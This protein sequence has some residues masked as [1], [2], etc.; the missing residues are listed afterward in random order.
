MPYFSRDDIAQ[1]ATPPGPAP[2]GAIRLSG[3][4]AFAILGRVVDEKPP[5]GMPGR[6]V[7]PARL[8]LR[9]AT[10][11]RPSGAREEFRCPVRVFLMPA[12]ASYTRED[13]VELH[14]SGAP[15]LLKAALSSLIAA[16]A[17]AAEPGEFTFRAFR[18]GRLGLA[19]AEAVEAVVRAGGDAERRRALAR[20]GDAGTARMLVWRDRVMDAAARLEA[21][22]DFSEEELEGDAA[23]GLVDLAAELEREGVGLAESDRGTADD[24]PH[25][26]LVGLTNA[27]KSS[28]LNALLGKDAV[29]ASPEASTTRDSLRHPVNWYGAA[30]ILSDNPGHDPGSPAAE[31]A[32]RRLGGE[33]LACWVVDGSC[34][35]DDLIRDFAGRLSGRVVVA[36]NKTD[37]PSAVAVDVWRGVAARTGVQPVAVTTVSAA[38]GYGIDGLRHILADLVRDLPSSSLW[39]R[40]ETFELTAALGHCRAAADELSGPGRLEL[41]SEELRQAALAFSRAMGEGYAEEAL[42]RIFSSFC[43]GK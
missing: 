19:Q 12:P 2:I 27:G 10:F 14:L 34:P 38:A 35:P 21:V 26:A 42:T 18:N 4:N 36:V 11:A 22:L 5:A 43:I 16:G 33:D 28:L 1:I 31:Q 9:L 13:V 3:D 24:L 37:L 15:V 39:N 6:V 23:A 20:L 25:V 29:L 8:R 40:R 41:A 17:R 30:F 7:Y 32:M